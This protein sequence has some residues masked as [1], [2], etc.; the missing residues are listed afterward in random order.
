M[1]SGQY[2]NTVVKRWNSEF[3]DFYK[4]REYTDIQINLCE[5]ILTITINNY[6]FILNKHYPFHPPNITI[7]DKPYINH[8]KYPTSRRIHKILNSDNITCMCCSSITNKNIWSPAYQIKDI[9]D[10]IGRLNELKNYVKNYLIIDDICSVKNIH[11][12]TIGML[13][14]EYLVSNTLKINNKIQK[15]I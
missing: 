3:L 11:T 12:D 4:N 14:L 5:D 7:Q 9:L 10:E 8:L 15:T 13:I 2:R 6:T 1:T